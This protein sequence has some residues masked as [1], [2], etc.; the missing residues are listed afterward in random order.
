MKADLHFGDNLEWLQKLPTGIVDLC[1]IDP[2]FNSS[3]NY[4][5]IVGGAQVKVFSDT[6]TWGQDDMDIYTSLLAGGGRVGDWAD[7]MMKAIKPCGM[8]SYLL[9]MAV[10]LIEIRRVLK[11][12][13]SIYLHCDQSANYHLRMLMDAIFGSSNCQRE[14]VWSTDT[15]SGYKSQIKGWVRGHDTVLFYSREEE[16]FT[17]NVEYQPYKPEYI[18][19]FKKDDGDGRKYRDDR[20]GGR[21]Q[22]LDESPGRRIGDVWADIMSFQQASTSSEI[23][24]YETQKPLALL[25]RIVKASSNPGDLVMDCFLGS[26]TTAEAALKNGRNFCG[27]DITFLA[28]DKAMARLKAMPEPPQIILT[29]HPET[30]DDARQLARQDQGR[31]QY[32][33]WALGKVGC[34]PNNER[35]SKRGKDSGIDGKK[36]VTLADGTTHTTIISVKSGKSKVRDLRD[37]MGTVD[38]DRAQRGVLLLLEDPTPDMKRDAATYNRGAKGE[39]KCLIFTAQDLIDGKQIPEVR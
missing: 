37:L 25:E 31:F 32:Q 35:T 13:G 26:G 17:F 4:N 7:G 23:V 18:A 12:T 27:C 8:Y 11:P 10:R 19:R 36:V 21:R 22:Y 5:V 3:A 6:W 30:L 34:A 2:P 24:G 39:E 38:R 16:D 15:V 9:F 20:S 29:G 28:V 33:A 1:Y 14:L